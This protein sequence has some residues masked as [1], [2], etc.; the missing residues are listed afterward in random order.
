MRIKIL[1]VNN[2]PIVLY[3]PKSLVSPVHRCLTNIFGLVGL[4]TTSL[5][6]KLVPTL[7]VFPHNVWI[8]YIQILHTYSFLNVKSVSIAV[9]SCRA[10]SVCFLLILCPSMQTTWTNLWLFFNSSEYVVRFFTPVLRMV[11]SFSRV[12]NW[13]LLISSMRGYRVFVYL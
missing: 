2:S 13:C 5:F 8:L 9:I 6:L 10:I 4:E 11:I 12:C 3:S 1:V 7:V